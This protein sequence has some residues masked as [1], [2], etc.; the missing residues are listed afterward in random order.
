VLL[1]HDASFSLALEGSRAGPCRRNIDIFIIIK[2]NAVN[3]YTPEQTRIGRDRKM[4]KQGD[5]GIVT[6]WPSNTRRSRCDVERSPLSLAVG[7]LTNAPIPR[8]LVQGLWTKIQHGKH[9]ARVATQPPPQDRNQRVQVRL[10]P[11]LKV[12]W[13]PCL[14]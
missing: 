12:T 7:D 8:G 11:V 1:L 5:W 4:G 14:T 2:E 10:R 3:E 9:K 13:F 6:R